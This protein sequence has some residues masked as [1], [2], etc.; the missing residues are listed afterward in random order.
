MTDEK[1]VF[2]VMKVYFGGKLDIVGVYWTEETAKR[3][4][5]ENL[6]PSAN[7]SI[8]ITRTTLHRFMIDLK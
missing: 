8:T 6:L 1:E 2:V 7:P 5:S 4:A 3:V